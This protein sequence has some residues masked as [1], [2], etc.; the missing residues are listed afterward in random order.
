MRMPVRSMS[1]CR[2]PRRR[3][4]ASRP[5]RA[6]TGWPVYGVERECAA[7][8]GGCP[9]SHRHGRREPVAPPG[10]RNLGSARRRSG[11]APQVLHGLLWE[12][13]KT[14]TP[15]AGEAPV[16]P[17]FSGIAGPEYS[18]SLIWRAH[19]PEDGELLWPRAR[20]REA[21]EIPDARG[22]RRARRRRSAPAGLRWRD[23]REGLQRRPSAR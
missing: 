15:P 18:V 11:R 20:D 22:A 19:V 14:T 21:V 2:R 10:R 12:W 3:R 6:P 13:M 1:I 4:A 5:P 7:A 16:E 23:D 9:A 17:Y 8:A